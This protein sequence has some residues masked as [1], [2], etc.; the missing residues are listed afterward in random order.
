MARE[1]SLQIEEVFK[2]MKSTYKVSCCY[3]GHSVKI[4]QNSLSD[5]PVVVIGTPG[6]LADH[7]QRKSF[8][9]TTV[10]LVVLDEFD[11]S[12]QMGFHKELTVIFKA[13]SGKQR[14]LLTSAT[15]LEDWPEF[16]PFPRPDTI[17][18]LKA[19]IRHR[20]FVFSAKSSNEIRPS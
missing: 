16:L 11:K 1:L 4:E 7:I 6:R 14:H 17:S 9:A 20:G 3:G 18:Y 12:L 15:R 13:L 5:S 2:S 10:Q 19:H 8:D